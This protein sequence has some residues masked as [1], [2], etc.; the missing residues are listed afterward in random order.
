[1]NSISRQQAEDH[2]HD[3]H[4]HEAVEKIRQIVDDA[5]NCFFR[6]SVDTGGSHA[7]RPMNVRKVDDA[8]DLWFLSANDS[9]TNREVAADPAVE[10]YF[11]GGK[12][13]EFLHLRGRCVDATTR[14]K[15][16]E[17]WEPTLKTWF[18]EGKDDPRISVLRVSPTDG[19]Y[20]DTKHGTL[21][22][23]VK[24]AI[25]AAMGKTLDDSIEGHVKV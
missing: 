14:E 6:T 23:G 13:S 25:G 20:W 22:A 5:E 16:D 4:D 9:H 11:Q 12:R 8:G 18:T 3:V 15:I 7:V 2:H 21:V 19:Y 1:M 24:M 10:L 17:L